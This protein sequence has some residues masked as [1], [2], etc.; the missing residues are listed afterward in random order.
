M[1]YEEYG[2]EQLIT[3]LHESSEEAKDILF[4]KKDSI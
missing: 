3:L 1:V 2:D 4:D